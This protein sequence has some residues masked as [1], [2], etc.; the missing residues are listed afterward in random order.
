MRHALRSLPTHT[1]TPH[2]PHLTPFLFY[3]CV[4]EGCAPMNF[5]LVSNFHRQPHNHP[6]HWHSNLPIRSTARFAGLREALTCSGLSCIE[7][8][9]DMAVWGGFT[10]YKGIKRCAANFLPLLTFSPLPLSAVTHCVCINTV[11]VL[12]GVEHVMRI[13]PATL[14]LRLRRNKLVSQGLTRTLYPRKL[15]VNKL[16]EVGIPETISH[17]LQNAHPLV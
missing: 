5:N 3:A 11:K 8:C 6:L 4:C 14:R 9:L 12:F 10:S 1:P 17:F 15:A 2:S 16:A 13:F 7:F